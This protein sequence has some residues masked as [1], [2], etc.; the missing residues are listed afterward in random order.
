M[1]NTEKYTFHSR[2]AAEEALD[3]LKRVV[4]DYGY[5]SL[6]DLND[7]CEIMSDYRENKFG[8]FKKAIDEAEVQYTGNGWFIVMSKP[9]SIDPTYGTKISYREYTPAKSSTPEPLCITIHT[10]ELDDVDATLAE[11]FKYIY[12]IKD[13]MVNLTIM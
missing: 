5:V 1:Y 7:Y 12:T 9:V 11:T 13:R 10:N 8:W 6:A 2:K 3:F 4:K